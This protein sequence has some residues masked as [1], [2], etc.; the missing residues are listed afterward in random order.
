MKLTLVRN[1]TAIVK[2]TLKKREE[3]SYN[4]FSLYRLFFS[5]P[6]PRILPSALRAFLC[7]DPYLH[8]SVTEVANATSLG[9][10]ALSFF[11]TCFSSTLRANTLNLE[12]S[13]QSRSKELDCWENFKPPGPA[14]AGTFFK[15]LLYSNAIL[16]TLTPQRDGVTQHLRWT[17]TDL[18]CFTNSELT[19]S[20]AYMVWWMWWKQKMWACF[21]TYSESDL[22]FCSSCC[23]GNRHKSTWVRWAGVDVERRGTRVPINSCLYVSSLFHTL[24]APRVW[25]RVPDVALTLAFTPPVV[26]PF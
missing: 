18:G 23:Q 1:F 25:G 3:S 19:D 11:D 16:Y 8:L 4:H 10:A 2:L 26:C 20:F 15:R 22:R 17:K 9:Q 6:L 13:C 7:M 24:A 5:K 21:P 12:A 14:M